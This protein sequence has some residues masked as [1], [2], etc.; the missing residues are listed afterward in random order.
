MG[1]CYIEGGRYVKKILKSLDYMIIIISIL[2]FGIGIVALYS[3]NGGVNG[4][5]SEVTKQMVWFL[6]GIA[7]MIVVLMIDY[8]LLGKLWIP[9]YILTILSLIAV[10][11]TPPINGATSWFQF[12]GVSIQPGEI[13]KITLIIGLR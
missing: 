7:G 3:A 2:L 1:F 10:L 8:D 13:A 12:G 5:T 9:I 4:D 11:F 6:V